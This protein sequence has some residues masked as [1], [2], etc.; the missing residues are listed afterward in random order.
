M[1]K[2]EY[3][4]LREYG[5]RLTE[6][7]LNALGNDEWGLVTILSSGSGE[8]ACIFKRPKS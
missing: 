2:W 4:I 6:G 1:Q 3:K 8:P 7:T 5:H